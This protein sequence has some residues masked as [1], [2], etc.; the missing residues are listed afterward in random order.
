[1]QYPR[2]ARIPT[3]IRSLA[4]LALCGISAHATV[5][6]NQPSL[7]QAPWASQND[8]GGSG[9]F[10]TVYDDFTLAADAT[11]V[12]VDWWGAYFNPG[13]Q[14]PITQFTEGSTLTH[15]WSPDGT[16]ILLC[17]RLGST[18]NL[19]VV[20]ADGSHPRPVTDFESGTI[21]IMKWS[22]DGSRIYFTYGASTQS[23]VL[24]RNFAAA[25]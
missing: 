16:L 7:A 15:E 10:A 6:Y 25:K 2:S 9:N 24:I 20:D 23:A 11:V 19:W 3:S 13:V 1:M 21:K 12:Q 17:R 18:D 8:P 4:V 5:V 14:G 22:P